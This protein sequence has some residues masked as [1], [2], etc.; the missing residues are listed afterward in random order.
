[1]QVQLDLQ[2]ERKSTKKASSSF[3]SQHWPKGACMHEWV[4]LAKDSGQRLLSPLSVPCSPRCPQHTQMRGFP[5]SPPA[6]PSAGW[7][8]SNEALSAQQTG[9]PW[10]SQPLHSQSSVFSCTEQLARITGHLSH[11]LDSTCTCTDLKPPFCE[12][13]VWVACFYSV[14]LPVSMYDISR[15]ESTCLVHPWTSLW[16]FLSQCNFF[17][18]CCLNG[19]CPAHSLIASRLLL[20]QERGTS[21]FLTLSQY[22]LKHCTF[23][24][25]TAGT[26]ID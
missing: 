4:R 14:S 2:I 9:L 25:W 10:H 1:M 7:R 26:G 19:M 23:C 8:G 22:Q 16:F 6:C 17:S 13:A 18:Q 5:I 20:S 3:T 15:G 11:L 21:W 24:L 12:Q